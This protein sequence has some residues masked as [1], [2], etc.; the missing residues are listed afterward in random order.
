MFS[1]TRT[2]CRNLPEALNA[3]T[4][5]LNEYGMP[6]NDSPLPKSDNYFEIF[7]DFERVLERLIIDINSPDWNWI[8]IDVAFTKTRLMDLKCQF[9]DISL[10]LKNDIL[11]EDIDNTFE[12]KLE[13]LEEGFDVV[14]KITN[15]EFYEETCEILS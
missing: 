1:D 2:K 15:L 12:D 6:F 13:I 8:A 10:S 14:S 7:R 3:C 5:Y 11:N 9:K 4:Q